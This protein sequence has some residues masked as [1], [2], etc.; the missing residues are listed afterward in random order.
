MNTSQAF[1]QRDGLLSPRRHEDTEKKGGKA[2]QA[3]M[4]LSG[5]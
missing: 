3:I 5:Y 1:Q 2:L 4:A